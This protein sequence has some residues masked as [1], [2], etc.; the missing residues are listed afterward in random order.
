MVVT[1]DYDVELPVVTL[2][3]TF[4]D[5]RLTDREVILARADL[6]MADLKL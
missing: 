1:T 3:F 4:N 5:M 2:S 6:N